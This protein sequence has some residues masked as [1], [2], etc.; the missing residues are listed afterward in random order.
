MDS[1]RMYAIEENVRVAWSSAGL[2]SNLQRCRLAR[3]ETSEQL[4]S[5]VWR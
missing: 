1:K 2:W 5:L 3:P 4:P